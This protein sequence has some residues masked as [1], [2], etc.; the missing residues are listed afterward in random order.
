MSFNSKANESVSFYKTAL[1]DIESEIYKF[2]TDPATGRKA[3]ITRE[4]VQRIALSQMMISFMDSNYL[5]SDDC[6]NEFFLFKELQRSEKDHFFVDLASFFEA[7][8]NQK[9]DYLGY[10]EGNSSSPEEARAKIFA[11]LN[12][13]I[14]TRPFHYKYNTEAKLKDN[15]N[16]SEQLKDRITQVN[17]PKHIRSLK[18]LQNKNYSFGGKK[19][20]FEAVEENVHIHISLDGS[21]RR[22]KFFK[23]FREIL[24]SHKIGVSVFDEDDIDVIYDEFK[25]DPISGLI[26]LCLRG[27][28][29][30]IIVITKEQPNAIKWAVQKTMMMGNRQA[31]KDNTI[32]IIEDR[33]ED[34]VPFLENELLKRRFCPD[35][36][37]FRI[38]EHITHEGLLDILCNEDIDL[39]Y[40][41][42]SPVK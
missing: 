19:Y 13:Y 30:H 11:I 1:D 35:P 36:E 29:T 33:K 15:K 12:W 20:R 39:G 31:A 17:E 27:C 18:K 28:D 4:I 3:T 23:K 38:V 6:R 42:K 34:I 9:A 37:N 10:L 8:P 2:D 40:L 32:F 5:T 14:N 22:Y 26:R 16:Q 7:N 24:Q 21:A 41:K 25:F